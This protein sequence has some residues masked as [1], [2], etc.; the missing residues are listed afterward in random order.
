MIR[1]SLSVLLL[2][3]SAALGKPFVCGFV[4]LEQDGTQRAGKSID[5]QSNKEKAVSTGD[6]RLLI[7]FGKFA[8]RLPA[9][10]GEHPN[11]LNLSTGRINVRS[12]E[13]RTISDFLDRSVAGSFA[14]YMY[15]MSRTELRLSGGSAPGATWHKS[16]DDVSDD[17]GCSGFGF[18]RFA[19]EVLD[20]AESSY[21]GAH[22]YSAYDVLLVIGPKFTDCNVGG[23]AFN[24]YTSPTGV[25]KPAMIVRVDDFDRMVGTLAHEYGHLMGLPELYD[26]SHSA[27]NFD[28][29]KERRE[30]EGQTGAINPRSLERRKAEEKAD[31]ELQS[32]GL[33]FWGVMAGGARGWE[34]PSAGQD[35]ASMNDNDLVSYDLHLG[36]QP[37]SAWSRKY[38]GWLAENTIRTNSTVTIPELSQNPTAYRISIAGTEQYFLFDNRQNS[39]GSMYT[40]HDPA[41]GLAIWHVDEN[42]GWGNDF[43]EWE[44]RKGVDLEC[45]D[46]LYAEHTGSEKNA[47]TG[48]DDLDKRHGVEDVRIVGKREQTFSGNSGDATDLWDGDAMARRRNFTPHTNPSSNGYAP[49]ETDDGDPPSDQFSTN[50]VG[51]DTLFAGL[52]TPQN[53]FSGIYIENI[54]DN[55]DG[56]MT[57]DVIFAPMVP[58][59]LEALGGSSKVELVWDAPANKDIA[60]ASYTINYRSKPAAPVK[61][62]VERGPRIPEWM[63]ITD[64]DADKTNYVVTGL[65]N[66]QAYEFE[67]CGVGNAYTRSDDHTYSAKKGAVVRAE[68]T[69][70]PSM[71]T[72]PANRAV[73]EVKAGTSSSNTDWDVS[74]GRYEL[75]SGTG[76]VLKSGDTGM[77]DAKMNEVFELRGNGGA[78]DL[79]WKNPPDHED[80]GFTGAPR[81]VYRIVIEASIGSTPYTKEVEI[82]VNDLE[83]KGSVRIISSS[84]FRVGSVL[85]GKVT[86]PDRVE[87]DSDG[88]TRRIVSRRATFPGSSP[89]I[90]SSTPRTEPD[91]C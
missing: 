12:G 40:A 52:G 3:A 18:R 65:E 71:M 33:G 57:F 36:P 91:P 14:D 43:N 69:P 35:I 31:L 28:E 54:R 22:A 82:T 64:I 29:R 1:F 56:S 84:S 72:G 50:Y 30:A 78:R 53:V 5:P 44:L 51:L 15:K 7:V 60:L 61:P 17:Y 24:Y 46:G 83:E 62:P 55:D 89:W 13:S 16:D 70:M 77:T 81:M 58:E 75:A 45:A 21:K 6:L 79:Y 27:R 47:E 2:L 10:G 26:R 19:D 68:G 66:G 87:T 8:D 39:G 37:M 74:L 67:L 48:V 25:S 86:D 90:P 4:G 20:N 59:N 76:W 49:W 80:S 23:T 73:D 63:S 9:D 85:T 88:C 38:V 41:S 42:T 11:P 34:V 32:A